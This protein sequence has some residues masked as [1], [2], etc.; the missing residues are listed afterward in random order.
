MSDLQ[1]TSDTVVQDQSNISDNEAPRIRR[2][3]TG[4]YPDQTEEFR[5]GLSR[6]LTALSHVSGGP[7][8]DPNAD[9]FD[10]ERFIRRALDR[11]AEEGLFQREIGCAFE[12]V[13]VLGSAAGVK[14]GKSVADV[15]TGPITLPKK[16]A[17]MR[18][19]KVQKRSILQGFTFSLRPGEMLLVLGRPGSGCSTFLKTVANYTGSFDAVEGWRD[20]DGIGP[21]EMA[22]RFSAETV[23][24]PEND[25]HF[26]LLTVGETLEF[27]SQSRS[28]SSNARPQDMT[29]KDYTHTVRDLLLTLFGLKHTF[30]T[31]V[32]GDYIRG[33][34]GGERKRVSIAEAMTTRARI[35]CQ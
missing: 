19:A 18:H 11:D 20:Y 2:Q 13:R 9:E 26:P 31:K 17:S 5:Q 22:K 21:E 33:V 12:D 1:N 16:I 10:L 6:R 7:S 4:V 28:P 27:A 35:A 32:G 29:R 34:S 3:P 15:L 23:Y 14:Y 24:L 8:T 25:I 30:N